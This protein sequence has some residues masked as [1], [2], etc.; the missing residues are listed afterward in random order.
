VQQLWNHF[1]VERAI[2]QRIKNS[3]PATR[4][5]IYAGMY[6]ELFAKVP[7]H[8]RL[9]RRASD[10]MTA[11]A[12]QSRLG[13]L[14][15]WIRSDAIAAEFAC[16]DA[17]FSMEELAPRV[18]HV[19]GI[20]ISDQRDPAAP[21][22]KNFEMITYNGFVLEGIPPGCVDFVFSDQFLEHLHPDEV[23]NHLRIVWNLL[24]PGGQ[25]IIR[26]PY[27]LTGPHDISAYFSDEPEGFHLHEWLFAELTE[28]LVAA[29]FSHVVAYWNKRNSCIPVPRSVIKGL[30]STMSGLPRASARK[31]S[32]Y[33]L[34]TLVCAATR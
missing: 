7:D 12:N 18:K 29:Q 11:A 15:S 4:M 25:Y 13:L 5:E 34:P 6:D 31:L 17:R 33:L 32:R 30:E 9:T 20:D 14:K 19:Y 1:L 23:S 26:T 10:K 2:A 24:K 28:S 21:I 8:P 27:A 3:S 16:G 22:P